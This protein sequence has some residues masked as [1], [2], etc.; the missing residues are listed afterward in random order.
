MGRI[1]KAEK[2]T[3]SLTIES[4]DLEANGVSRRDGKVVFVA[5]ALPGERVTVYTTRVKPK[6]DV[7]KLVS[8]EQESS[9]RVKPLCPNYGV[10]GGCSMQ[11]LDPVSQVSMKQRALED[12]LWHIGR[13]RPRTMMRPI[14]GPTWGYRYRAR[15]SVRDVQKKGVVLV[16][17]HEKGSSFVADMRECLVLPPA[18]SNLLLPLRDLVASLSIRNRIPQIEVA[19]G[20]EVTAFVW[21]VLDP[22]TAKDIELFEAFEAEHSLEFWLQTKGLDTVKRLNDKPSRLAYQLPEFGLR[23]PFKPTDFTQVNH[24]I[25]MVLVGRALSLLQVQ[26]HHRV[27]DL[28]CG[29][30]NFTLPLATQARQVVGIEGSNVLTARAREAAQLAGLADRCEFA[31]E[32]LFEFSPQRWGELIAPGAFDRILIDPPREGALEVV[33]VLA[34]APQ[35]VGKIVYVSCNPATLARDVGVLTESGGY[36]LVS[37]GVINMFPHTAHVESIAVF[38]P[39]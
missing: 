14:A 17:F 2:P 37:A 19:V 25:N 1:D 22:P 34:S 16:G 10:C 38:E 36:S 23:M 21:R 13:V 6:F 30:G 35:K 12:C 15:L 26:A 27:L 33:K 11:H 32:N 31:T 29:L 9:Q 4:V 39:S 3:Y 8:I 28:F 24:Q 20:D 18:L 5:G 7:A